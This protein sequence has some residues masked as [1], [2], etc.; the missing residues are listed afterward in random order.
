MA[1]V[2]LTVED[3]TRTGLAQT[4]TA[5]DATDTYTF[6]NDGRTVLFF[7]NAGAS[8]AT[9]TVTSTI[10]IDGQAVADR[11]YT[12]P[13]NSIVQPLGPFNTSVYNDSSDLVTFSNDLA[14]GVTV[15]VV[16]I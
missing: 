11:T 3:A 8:S 12:L 5:I 14:T 13:N 10:T 6:S 1:T 15:G 9:I 4:M 16:R 7:I 2:N